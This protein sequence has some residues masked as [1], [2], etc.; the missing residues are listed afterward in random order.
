MG[1]L[2]LEKHH[3]LALKSDKPAIEEALRKVPR[4]LRPKLRDDHRAEV[5]TEN[6]FVIDSEEAS[7]DA[8]LNVALLR[9]SKSLHPRIH[10]LV[11]HNVRFAETSE[12]TVSAPCGDDSYVQPVNPRQYDG[13]REKA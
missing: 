6:H 5:M 3:V 2:E 10:D 4:P 12:M 8:I 11:L 9:E 7:S 1:G 13:K